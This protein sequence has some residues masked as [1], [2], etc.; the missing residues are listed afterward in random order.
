MNRNQREIVVCIHMEQKDSQGAGAE[1][2]VIGSSDLLNTGSQMEKVRKAGEGKKVILCYSLP[3]KRQQLSSPLPFKPPS[4]SI[5]PSLSTSL[6]FL[7]FLV[8]LSLF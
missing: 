3:G 2:V 4:L 1:P 7:F 5:S 8:M 6:P